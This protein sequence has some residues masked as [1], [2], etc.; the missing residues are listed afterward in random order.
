M[1]RCLG[2]MVSKGLIDDEKAGAQEGAQ[3][4]NPAGGHPLE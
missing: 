1:G 3:D 4:S 2:G